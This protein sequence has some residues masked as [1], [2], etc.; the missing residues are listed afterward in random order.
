LKIKAIGGQQLSRFNPVAFR[1]AAEWISPIAK[2]FHANGIFYHAVQ[3]DAFGDYD[4]L[5]HLALHCCAYETS[6]PQQ[7]RRHGRFKYLAT[8]SALAADSGPG[9]PPI[10]G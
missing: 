7:Q 3:E 10:S 5:G 8:I 6:E 4:L 2:I 9:R 1:A